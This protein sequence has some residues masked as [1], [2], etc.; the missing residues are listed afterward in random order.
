MRSPAAG[1]RV[2]ISGGVTCGMCGAP[3]SPCRSPL[4]SQ[5]HSA[6][7]LA[8]RRRCK[9]AVHDF[10]ARRLYLDLSAQCVAPRVAGPLPA[11]WHLAHLRTRCTPPL[12][13]VHPVG[14]LRNSPLHVIILHSVFALQG[15]QTYTEKPGHQFAL[16]YDFDAVKEADY[17]GL[18]IPGQV[19]GE[20]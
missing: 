2:E 20:G 9:T 6:G 7:T 17:D 5:T 18:V 3:P 1:L 19:A 16:N 4:L 12:S 10:E 13:R 14:A 11:H 8:S 15:D